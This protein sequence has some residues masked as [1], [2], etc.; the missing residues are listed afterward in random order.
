MNRYTTLFLASSLLGCS[1]IDRRE[2]PA[3]GAAFA[4]VRLDFTT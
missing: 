2:V 4:K 1:S 3:D